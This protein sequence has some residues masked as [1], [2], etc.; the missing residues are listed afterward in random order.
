MGAA[1]AG[2]RAGR[3][4]RARAVVDALA[5]AGVAEIRVVNRSPER[6]AALAEAA[7][8]S[9][10]PLPWEERAAALAGC[11]LLVNTTQLGQAGKPAL[12]LDLGRLPTDAVVYDLVYAPL[13]TALLRAA[14]TRGNGAVDG[15]GMLI[16]QARPGFAAWF[17]A[18]ADASAALRSFAAAGL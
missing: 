16:H 12:E 18:E 15:L 1:G 5:A 6:A 13:E 8:G 17:G 9:V 2:L 14:R 3:G 7:G 11:G 4:R 10:R